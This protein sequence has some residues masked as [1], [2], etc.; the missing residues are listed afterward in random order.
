M[1]AWYWRGKPKYSGITSPSAT[2][3]IINLTRTYLLT[4]LLSY[5]FTYSMEKSPSW[6][7]NRFAASQEVSLI[8]WNPKFHY[9]IHNFP[10]PVYIPSQFNL[11]HTPTFHFPKINLNINIP[12]TPGSPE[13]CLSLRF[14][15]QNPVYASLLSHTRYMPRSSHYS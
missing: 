15:H 8:L 14:P 11:V 9:R 3:S 13:W 6:G 12:S 5:L 4:C 7:S 2:E 1:M 10:P